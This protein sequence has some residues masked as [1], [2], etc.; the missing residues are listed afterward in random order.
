MIWGRM[1]ESPSIP[2]RN[3]NDLGHDATDGVLNL[4]RGLPRGRLVEHVVA[5]APRVRIL[6][7]WK[8]RVSNFVTAFQMRHRT[9]KSA[10]HWPFPKNRERCGLR[11]GLPKAVFQYFRRGKLHEL[12]HKS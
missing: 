1:R 11:S 3:V 9:Q 12:G 4:E 5:G 2:R 6:A 7:L 8:I 10:Q